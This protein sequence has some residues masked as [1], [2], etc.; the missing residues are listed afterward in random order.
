[1]AH[2]GH[3]QQCLSLPCQGRAS[4]TRRI[5]TFS[6]T[7]PETR[8]LQRATVLLG[9]SSWKIKTAGCTRQQVL[10]VHKFSRHQ[11]STHSLMACSQPSLKASVENVQERD[12]PGGSGAR[13]P[14]TPNA[15]GLGS[16]SGQGTRSHI[17][18]ARSL[19]TAM[20]IEDPPC[21]N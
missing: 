20:N 15:G 7:K 16:I 21:C 6:M 14:C 18:T 17:A 5:G 13:T 2:P 4:S 12:F 9:D 11:E 3:I 19:H 1:M 10:K 8:S